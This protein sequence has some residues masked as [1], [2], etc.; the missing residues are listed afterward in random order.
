MLARYGIGLR[1]RTSSRAAHTAPRSIT[2]GTTPPCRPQFAVPP[3]LRIASVRTSP[4][5]LD[6]RH[7]STN[8]AVVHEVEVEDACEPD[9]EVLH[10]QRVEE[11]NARTGSEAA[12]REEVNEDTLV[13]VSRNSPFTPLAKS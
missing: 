6:A 13:S 1:A 8:A 5:G 9:G 11:Q 4:V 3:V 10:V 7:G 2:T 12:P